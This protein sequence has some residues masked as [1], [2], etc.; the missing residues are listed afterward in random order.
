MPALTEYE[1]EDNNFDVTAQV[2][3]DFNKKG[4]IL[5]RK[6]LSDAELSRVRAA[7][8]NQGVL[9]DYAYD[10]DDGADKQSRMCLWRHPGNDVT[11]MLARS[12]KVAGT[13]EKLLDGE[14][15][16]YHSKLMMKEAYTGGRFVWHQDYGYWYKNTCLFPDMLT[17]FIAIDP[18]RLENGCLQV[19]E[20]SH[21]C[22]KIE[23]VLCGAQLGAEPERLEQL[24]S[25]CPLVS[26]EMNPGDASLLPLNLLHCSS[27]NNGPNRRW[28]LA[29]AYNRADNDPVI[30]HHHPKYTKLDK[31]PNSAIMETTVD[32]D[33]PS[34]DMFTGTK[35]ADFFEELKKNELQKN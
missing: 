34:K 13:S 2:K 30:E 4:Y 5:V 10:V 12:E 8:D 20:G 25:R 3:D 9:N 23:H 33:L 28:A 11:G 35:R 6:L 29:I 7:L 1:L 16:H 26:V 21:R 27:Q 31:V 17:V 24:K 14:V 19:L 22:G 15:Y 32:W 18:C